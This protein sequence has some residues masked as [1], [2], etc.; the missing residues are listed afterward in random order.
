MTPCNIITIVR[1][2]GIPLYHIIKHEAQFKIHNTHAFIYT[3][4][5]II[6]FPADFSYLKPI[7]M[8]ERV[9]G[10]LKFWVKFWIWNK[11]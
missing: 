1:H 3:N 7:Q 2:E 9:K 5:T 10:H 4:H 11:F 8:Y 6:R